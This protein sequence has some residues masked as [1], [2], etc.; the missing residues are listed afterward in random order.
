M[1]EP[2]H[3]DTSLNGPHISSKSSGGGIQLTLADNIVT[4]SC[5]YQGLNDLHIAGQ[6]NEPI[7]MRSSVPRSKADFVKKYHFKP[8]VG[9]RVVAPF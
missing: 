1:R 3:V 6:S 2:F 4:V 9:M 7:H 5:W 8:I